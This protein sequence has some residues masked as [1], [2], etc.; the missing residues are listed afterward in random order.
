MKPVFQLENNKLSSLQYRNNSS[1]EPWTTEVPR[2]YSPQSF[3]QA[4]EQQKPI[5]PNEFLLK[6]QEHEPLKGPCVKSSS[7]LDGIFKTISDKSL[8]SYPNGICKPILDIINQ[9]RHF[10]YRRVQIYGH[11]TVQSPSTFRSRKADKPI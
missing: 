1:V 3:S 11:Y 7:T 4:G 10:T 2:L 6:Q 5:F 8:S 9:Q